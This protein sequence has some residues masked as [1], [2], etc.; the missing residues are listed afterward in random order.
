MSSEVKIGARLRA[1]RLN[2]G[3]TL[4]DVAVAAGISQGFVSKLERDQV[5][6]SVSTLVAICSVVGLRVGQLF[7][8]PTSK[9]VRA[10][11]GTEINFGGQGAREFLLT[12]GGQSLVEVIYSVIEPSG[13]AGDG[14]YSLDSDV[15]LVYVLSG[16]LALTLGEERITLEAGDS[17]AFNGRDPHTW[18]NASDSERAVVLWVL[19]PAS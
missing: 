19:A 15:E 11:Q 18:A 2:K 4:E 14:L 6:P 8:T 3:L 5:S 10:G 12:P 13:S 1:A 16:Q 7:E 17:A 9:V